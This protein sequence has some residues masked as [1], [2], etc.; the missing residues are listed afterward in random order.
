[1]RELIF[2]VMGMG[3]MEL[4]QKITNAFGT[5]FE[6]KAENFATKQDV[7]EMRTKTEEVQAEFH[8]INERFDADLKF[9]Y[10]FFEDQYKKL[11]G[12]LFEKVCKSEALRCVL[13][14]TATES[15]ML[16]TFNEMPIVRFENTDDKD[17]NIE[18]KIIEEIQ[19]NY[20]YASPDLLKWM[21]V[22]VEID[23]FTERWNGNV[24][25]I[26]HYALTRMIETIIHDYEIL[27]EKLY[28]KDENVEC[29]TLENRI[30]MGEFIEVK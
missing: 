12:G 9:K 27:R 17:D 7:A 10:Q 14:E 16:Y 2:L 25:E 8:R 22:I 23:G 5:Y 11:Y 6:K 3:V 13:K 18:K 24:D 30:K 15:R 28:L 1:M 29:E 20:I 19:Q 21:S 26:R 4:L